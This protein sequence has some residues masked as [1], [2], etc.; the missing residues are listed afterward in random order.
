M[1]LDARDE[2]DPF[3]DTEVETLDEADAE[4]LDRT[5]VVSLNDLDVESIDEGGAVVD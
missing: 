3:D 4:S 2:E 5:E 1:P